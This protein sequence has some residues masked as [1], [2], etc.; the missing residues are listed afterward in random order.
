MQ[1]RDYKTEGL[2]PIVDQSQSFICGYSD[3][4]EAVVNTTSENL[5]VFGDHT[6]TLK[7]IDFPYIQGADGI[8]IFKSSKSNEI[9]ERFLYQTLLY[10]P[11]VSNEYKRHFSE[12]KERI[13]CYPN[14]LNEQR[15][16]ATCLSSMDD[17]INAYTEKISLLGQ[18]KKGLMQGMFPFVETPHCDV[19]TNG[20]TNVK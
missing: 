13:V 11:I 7:F 2:F 4:A 8:K 17:T 16:I 10:S 14:D 18:Y 20:Q 19:S 9:D 15:K 3:D 12:L 1:T 6:C 5:I